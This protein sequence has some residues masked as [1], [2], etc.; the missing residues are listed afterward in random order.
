MVEIK[1]KV[2]IKIPKSILQNYQNV[3]HI[4]FDRIQQEYNEP[5]GCLHGIRKDTIN[6]SEDNI[7][8]CTTR[9]FLA[10]IVHHKKTMEVLLQVVYPNKH[11]NITELSV[12]V[13]ISHCKHDASLFPDY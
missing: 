9:F 6:G 11:E 1:E 8:S 7:S 2:P 13:L 4:P 12:H 10:E 3:R 5:E